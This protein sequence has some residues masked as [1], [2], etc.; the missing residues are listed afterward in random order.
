MKIKILGLLLLLCLCACVSKKEI[1][2]LQDADENATGPIVYQNP[3]IQPNDILKITVESIV[4]EA[5]IPYNKNVAQGV[6]TQNLQLLQLEGYLVSTNNTIMFPVLGE[7]STA[8]L[9]SKQLES[10][11]KERLE[12]GGHL[13][14]TNVSVRLLNAKVTV[15]GEVN[16]PGTYSFTETSITVFQALGLAGDLTING[17]REDILLIREIDGKRTISHIDL[18]TTKWF[19]SDSYYIKPNDVLVVNPNIKQVKSS[20]IIGDT[21]TVLGVAS[22]IISITIL[23]TR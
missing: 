6:V 8:G 12:N 18:T 4:P 16:K 9:T 11:I 15:L 14:G 19:D 1:L 22:L 2:Y 10:N 5:S 20:G 17:Q 13:K 21:S 7:I 3:T 23:L